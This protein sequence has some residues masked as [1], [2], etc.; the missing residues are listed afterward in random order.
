MTIDT[1]ITHVTKVGSNL[2][3]E[4]GFDDTQAELLHVQ[5]QQNINDAKLL[6]EQ[7]MTELSQ[8][9]Q[10]NHFKQ[11]EAAE[12]LNVTRPR[13]SD[14]VNKKTNKFTFDAL[15]SMLGRAGKKVDFSI[16]S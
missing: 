8:W 5:S 14:L 10:D 2:F 15:I 16:I 6:K 9:I 1:S 13:V 11:S 7:L 12:R 3:S 4:L